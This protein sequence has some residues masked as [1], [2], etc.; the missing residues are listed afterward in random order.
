MY[1]HFVMSRRLNL[2]RK[3]VYQYILEKTGDYINLNKL[4]SK[5]CA[6]IRVMNETEY[7]SSLS[8]RCI[9]IRSRGKI[10]SILMRNLFYGVEQR[11]FLNN[12]R[13]FLFF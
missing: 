4:K 9:S 12:P 5:K 8:G 2:K 6:E 13:I 11:L 1:L 3:K 7:I 10:S